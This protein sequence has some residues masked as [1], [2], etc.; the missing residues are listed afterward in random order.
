VT[1]G[2][3]AL[4]LPL[5]WLLLGVDGLIRDGAP[6]VAAAGLTLYGL[7]RARRAAGEPVGAVA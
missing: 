4:D 6:L 1:L 3:V 5:C 2:V 7:R